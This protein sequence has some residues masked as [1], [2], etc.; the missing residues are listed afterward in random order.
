MTRKELKQSDDHNLRESGIYSRANGT[1]HELYLSG[2]IETPELYI[3][4]MD[5][6]RNASP[7]D[8]IVIH[9][10]SGG[11][12]IDTALQMLRC[13]SETHAHVT[14]S[15]EGSCMSA[16]TMIFLAG[17]TLQVSPHS[18]FMFHNYSGGTF[19]KGGEMY[20]NV[21]FEREWSRRFLQD[22]YKNFLTEQEIQAM[23][24]NKDIWMHSEE[25]VERCQR[26]A[27]IMAE[28]HAAKEQVAEIE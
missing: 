20:D 15:V 28:E 27:K 17:D 21:V 23:L 9:I 22:I 6:I 7:N 8:E 11:G 12:V 4:W 24:D 26:R 3:D 18:L 25:V 13:I 19:G 1:Y 16:A 10:N 14:C 2:A 5:V